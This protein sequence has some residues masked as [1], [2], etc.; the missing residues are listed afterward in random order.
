M[1]NWPNTPPTACPGPIRSQ[2]RLSGGLEDIYSG[3]NKKVTI[4]GGNATGPD[5]NLVAF[6]GQ[7][8]VNSMRTSAVFQK[9]WQDENGDS[10]TSNY[11]GNVTITYALQVSNDGGRTWTDAD[12]FFT[13]AIPLGKMGGKP[14]FED[15]ITQPANASAGA[16]RRTID[17]LPTAIKNESSTPNYT[18]LEYR[19]VERTIT[20]ALPGQGGM[21]VTVTVKATPPD[22]GDNGQYNLKVESENS[23]NLITGAELAVSGITSTSTNTLAT[24]DL[25]GHQDLG[26]RR[27]PV[28][29]PSRGGGAWIGPSPSW[30]SIPW[31][32]Q[33][34]VPSWSPLPLVTA[35]CP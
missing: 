4:N 31:M 25:E 27:Q 23:L 30:C 22:N 14:A 28:Q 10:V 24:V 19:V 32:A 7:N 13:D 20:Y 9:K 15:T 17:D 3:G 16:W 34:G 29:H 21:P 11:L 26:G 18:L 33:P 5:G 6:A 1:V 2:K 35:Q 12:T 8:L